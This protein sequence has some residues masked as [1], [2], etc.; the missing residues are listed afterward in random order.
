MEKEE[1]EV[2]ALLTKG[3]LESSKLL[4]KLESESGV[5]TKNA[6]P[7]DKSTIAGSQNDREAPKESSSELLKELKLE[8]RAQ[9]AAMSAKELEDD[10]R[11]VTTALTSRSRTGAERNP[12]PENDGGPKEETMRQLLPWVSFWDIVFAIVPVCDRIFCT[13]MGWIHSPFNCALPGDF[14]DLMHPVILHQRSL[15]ISL[16]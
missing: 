8:S 11:E 3:V 5:Q 6:L 10:R 13:S 9:V 7:S 2:G 14:L 12:G 4:S 15:T 1:A 16:F